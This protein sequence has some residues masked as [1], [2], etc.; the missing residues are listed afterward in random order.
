MPKPRKS[1][2]KC[3]LEQMNVT[4]EKKKKKKPIETVSLFDMKR[5]YGWWP[6]MVEEDEKWEL[7]V[8]VLILICR[9]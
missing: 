7:T 1:S 3:S 2:G 9:A 6:C 4:T 5:V 8:S